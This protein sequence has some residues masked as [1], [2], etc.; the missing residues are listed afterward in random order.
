MIFDCIL[1]VAMLSRSDMVSLP[2]C[3][4]CNVLLRLEDQMEVS[5]CPAAA[6]EVR[7]QDH[8]MIPT[9]PWPQAQKVYRTYQKE[10]EE[11]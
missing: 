11:R 1:C 4:R 8:V 6:L 5:R 9:I 2:E 3:C 7:A 10:K